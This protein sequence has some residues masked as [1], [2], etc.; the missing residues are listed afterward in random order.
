[1]KEVTINA[2]GAAKSNPGAAAIAVIITDESG[3]V[4][5]K[6]VESIGNATDV[7]AAFTAVA[8]GL[9]IA[10]QEFGPLTTDMECA[11][12]L[13]NDEVKQQLNGEL[14][15]MNPGI[16]PHFI[17]IHNLRV[18]S[19]PNLTFTTVSEE[20]NKEVHKLVTELLDGN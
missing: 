17:E 7:Y 1:M 19:F 4:L 9:D 5:N 3:K 13:S 14:P 6:T 10:A 20:Q 11:V 16:V 2:H 18:A 15:I 12:V 8:R